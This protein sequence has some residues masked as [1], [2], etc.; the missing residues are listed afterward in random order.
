MPTSST[1]PELLDTGDAAALVFVGEDGT[2]GPALAVAGWRGT[3]IAVPG[4][5]VEIHWLELAADLTQAQAAAAARLML[6][7]ASAEPLEQMHVAV[8]RSEA[9][10]TPAA[11]V[12]NARM[13]A[14]LG[15]GLDPDLILPSPM[16]LP[17]PGAG[18]ARRNSGETADYRGP[19]AAFSIEPELAAPLTGDAPIEEIGPAEFEAG[20]G[21]ILAAPPLN[22]RQGPFARRRQWKLEAGRTRR[23]VLLGLALAVLSLLVQIVMILGY[24][25]A[26]DRAEAEMAELSAAA[27]GRADIRPGFGPTAALFFEAIRAT[28]NVE[29]T[30]LE[31]RPDGSLTASL[32]LDNPATLAAFRGRIEASGLRVEGGEITTSAGRP[33]T[34][35][36]VRPS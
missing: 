1:E 6:A 32:A 5:Q 13:A 33:T 9:G 16:L 22:L 29:M 4:T 11:L 28:P 20:L 36:T 17:V 31:Y 15:S 3:A 19:G 14:W 18:F 23:L 12:P 34:E 24:T 10:L 2:L 25:F 26:A 27:P 8:G 35:L 7:D 21:A 30:R